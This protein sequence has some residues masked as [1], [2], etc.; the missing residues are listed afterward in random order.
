VAVPLRGPASRRDGGDDEAVRERHGPAPVTGG[1]RDRDATRLGRGRAHAGIAA[2]SGSREPSPIRI[3]PAPHARGRANV[4]CS[5]FLILRR[6]SPCLGS[7][8]RTSRLARAAL[9]STGAGRV[10]TIIPE[11]GAGEGSGSPGFTPASLAAAVDIVRTPEHPRGATSPFPVTEGKGRV[12]CVVRV[13]GTVQ[14]SQT[15]TSRSDR[16]IEGCRSQ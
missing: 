1:A 12:A 11:S 14:D 10:R 6:R 16:R 8:S 2:P 5:L 9:Q 7:S 3:R 15:A 4:E 13:P